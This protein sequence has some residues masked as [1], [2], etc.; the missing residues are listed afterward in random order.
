MFVHVDQYHVSLLAEHHGPK[1]HYKWGIL[2]SS[3]V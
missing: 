3:L 2:Q 1:D